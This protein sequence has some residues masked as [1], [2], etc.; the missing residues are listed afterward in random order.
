MRC[1]DF[2][3]EENYKEYLRLMQDEDYSEVTFDEA[4]GGVSAVHKNHRLDKQQGLYGERRGNYE[5]RTL[6][7]LRGEGHRIVLLKESEE[8]GVKQ[9]DGLLDGIPCEI[10][11]VEMMGRWTVRTK[12]ANAIRQGAVYVVLFFADAALFSEQ[13]IREGW[14][15]CLLYSKP[16]EIVPEI[17]LLCIAGGTVHEIEKPSW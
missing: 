6:E 14:K 16:N 9:F 12:I 7:A 15:E 2:Q 5:I 10:K 17:K 3:L 4:S 8:V 13:R 11:A 1:S